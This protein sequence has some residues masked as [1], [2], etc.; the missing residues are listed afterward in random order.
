MDEFFDFNDYRHLFNMLLQDAPHGGRGAQTRLA[1]HLGCQQAFLSRVSAGL[2]ELSPEQA[3]GVSTYFNLNR[4]EKEFWLNLVS[5]TRAGNNDLKNYYREKKAK[6][7]DEHRSL[8]K[9]IESGNKLNEVEKTYYYSDWYYMAVHILV[10]IKGFDNEEAL[11]GKL[12]LS[13]EI[14]RSCLEHLERANLVV[15]EGGIYKI[16][17]GKLHLPPNNPLINKHHINWRLQTMQRLS[18]PKDKDLHYTAIMSCSHKDKEKVRDIL[19]ESVTKI[20]SLIKDSPDEALCHYA[21]DY[22]EI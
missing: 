7:R 9:R 11:A 22:F 16:S 1:R 18:K 19:T 8:H 6:I 21:V 13:L 12:N 17:T 3:F 5:E 15:K 14:I 4:L 10:G 2:A 20:R